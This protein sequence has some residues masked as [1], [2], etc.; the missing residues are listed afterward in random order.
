MRNERLVSFFLRAGLATVFLYAAIASLLEPQNWTGYLPH[1]LKTIFPE[2]LLL[3]AFSCYEILLSFW[4][5]S[6]KKIFHAAVLA[7]VTLFMIIV[8]NLAPSLFDV[9]FRDVAILSSAIALAILE[10]K[11]ARREPSP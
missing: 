2:R 11:P 1:F 5:L 6:N 10:Y 8:P 3:G 7:A 9:V 4:L